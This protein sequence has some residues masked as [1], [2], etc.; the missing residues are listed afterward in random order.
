MG[1]GLARLSDL[2][3]AVQDPQERLD[4]QPEQNDNPTGNSHP[5]LSFR[6]KEKYA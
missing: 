3:K 6:E 1:I 4:S 2:L 5:C